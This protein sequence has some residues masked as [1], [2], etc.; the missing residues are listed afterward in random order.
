MSDDSYNL[1]DTC[2]DIDNYR[3]KINKIEILEKNN[4]YGTNIYNNEFQKVIE[5]YKNYQINNFYLFDIIE[6]CVDKNILNYSIIQQIGKCAIEASIESEVANNLIDL[7]ESLLVQDFEEPDFKI[8]REIILKN[9]KLIN[10]DSNNFKEIINLTKKEII[11][12]KLKIKD[13][14]IK[15]LINSCVE[16]RWTLENI[17]IFLS[18]LKPLYI[19][20]LE[21]LKDEDLEKVTR[22]NEQK[23]HTAKSLLNIITAFPHI[24]L[25]EIMKKIKFDNISNIARDFYI[26]CASG[27]RNDK[28]GLDIT[29]LINTLQKL[30]KNYFNKEKINMF[31]DQI[32]ICKNII[33]KKSN[34]MI[35]KKDFNNW[36]E[37]EFPAFFEG[38]EIPKKFNKKEDKNKII[39]KI[40]ANISLG[41]LSVKKIKL[42]ESQI[43]AILICIDNFESQENIDINKQKGIIEEIATGEGKSIIICCLAAYFGLKKHKVDIITSSNLL[44]ERDAKKYKKF[45]ELFKLKVTYCKNKNDNKTQDEDYPSPYQSDIDIVYGTFLAFE[46]DLLDG[47]RN[48]E[49]IRK[50]RK[51]DI[52]I[53]DEV[54][55]AFIDC[56]E[57]STQLSQSSK[58]YQFLLPMYVSIYFFV[59]ILDNLY[60]EE[61]KKQ[62]DE[63]ISR[64]DYKNL[65]DISQK[66]ILDKLSDDSDRKDIFLNYIENYIKKILNEINK[67]MAVEIDYETPKKTIQELDDDVK[68]INF[69]HFPYFLKDFVETNLSFWINSAFVAKNEMSLEKNYTLSSRI[70]GFKTITPIDKKNTGEL[71]FNT[72]Y[73]RGLHQMLQIK[74]RV[75]LL[76][77]TLDHTFMSHITYFSKYLNKKNFFG[78]TGTIGGEE[79]YKIYKNKYFNSNLIFMPTN[80]QKKFIELPAKICAE[81]YEKHLLEICK[82]IIFHFS[83]GRKILVICKDIKEGYKIKNLLEEEKFNLE[84]KQVFIND[85]YK[86]DIFLYVRND[87]NN[88]EKKLNET[89]KRIIIATNLGGRGTDIKTSPE[90]EEKGGLHVIITKV[91]ENSRTQK[92]A[93][94]R[95]SRQGKKGSGQYIFTEKKGLKTYN[96]LIKDRDEKEKNYIDNIN[97]DYLILKDKLFENYINFIN[98]MKD[99]ED[100]EEKYIKS[101]IDEK[102]ALFLGKNVDIDKDEKDVDSAF[103][104]FMNQI[105]ASMENQR[106]E[107]FKNNFLRIIDG[108][109]QHD[110]FSSELKNFFNFRNN[111]QC[112]YF[113]SSYYSARIEYE[114]HKRQFQKNIND[115]YFCKEIVKYLKETK[116]KL[117]K[118]IE[119]NIDPILKSFIDW[120]KIL[121]IDN[122]LQ[123]PKNYICNTEKGFSTQ[124]ENR[125]IIVKKLIEI[126]DQNI[127]IVQEYIDKYLP[128]NRKGWEALLEVEDKN[129]YFLF[130]NDEKYKNDI[131]DYIADA[132]LLHTFKFYIRKKIFRRNFKYWLFYIG[133]FIF[134]AIFTTVKSLIT[135]GLSKSIFNSID[136]LYAKFLDVKYVDVQ[137]QNSVFSVIKTK[138]TSFISKKEKKVKNEIVENNKYI[139]IKDE[140]IID[141]K[142]L[143][144]KEDFEVFET[145]TIEEIKEY[146]KDIFRKN[147]EKILEPTKFLLLIDSFY[148][149]TNWRDIIIKD[150]IIDY[151]NKNEKLKEKTQLIK[152]CNNKMKHQMAL[153]NLKKIIKESIIDIINKIKAKFDSNDYNE[154]EI[155]R[156]EDIIIQICHVDINT[157]SNIVTL[158]LSQ[159]VIDKNE[160]FNKDLFKDEITKIDR[161]YRDRDTN[162]IKKKKSKKLDKNINNDMKNQTVK[163]H[164]NTPYP[165]NINNIKSI[166]HFSLPANINISIE[167]DGILQDVQFLYLHKGYKNPTNL[168]MRDFSTKIRNL[169]INLYDLS[170]SD[171]NKDVEIF[172]E[173]MTQKISEIIETYLKEEIYPNILIQKN[174]KIEL[175]NEEQKIYDLISKNSGKKAIDLLESKE[176]FKLK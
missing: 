43:L 14:Y 7:Y 147:K 172:F 170:F 166:N 150:I 58:G 69:F 131:K 146:I 77:E 40:I 75:R 37:K 35:N 168:L 10:R 28:K 124:F 65:N 155:K 103:K 70:N 153:D 32:E 157:A 91:S 97:L 125:K 12:N 127:S 134:F 1:D 112:F 123:I 55:N 113:A 94:G 34:T 13:E 117:N 133:F 25:I 8:I 80:V 120:E 152:L 110:N 136:D 137:E 4:V 160:I 169:L 116:N 143:L 18:F 122:L 126:V 156:L 3:I 174:K 30:N 39:A 60:L 21:G 115:D 6:K 47:I 163:I 106:P 149:Q 72:H 96:Q 119:I 151:F 45:F 107:K 144:T 145:K 51:F 176:L 175:N 53:I 135:K 129:I 86:K 167:N 78:F 138:L 46:G 15:D 171:M 44:A 59:D 16:K 20:S 48:N 141:K 92:Q 159:N 109:N 100:E 36:I 98:Q 108:V 31:Q 84:E 2:D 105:N 89:E 102:W 158:I 164:Y 173:E 5:S 66:K 11:I 82:E 49:N 132:G 33:A 130:E 23:I 22:E 154:K 101:D 99:L 41:L 19:K 67:E 93:F 62:Y 148:R 111:S 83:I 64:E 38:N 79:T 27:K 90:V 128:S 162:E 140:N 24:N 114:N 63:I 61:V 29:E 52:I 139:E 121:K 161:I 26:Q 104:I 87:E 118:L 73:K 68:L 76:P 165:Q 9:L 88:L 42:Y 57:G 56:I 74:E 50:N 95:T 81:D 54:D 85:N 142:N 17:K 71:E